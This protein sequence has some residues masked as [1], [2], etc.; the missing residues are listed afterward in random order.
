MAYEFLTFCWTAE[1]THACCVCPNPCIRANTHDVS[2]YTSRCSYTCAIWT[3]RRRRLFCSYPWW[4]LRRLRPRGRQQLWSVHAPIVSI[5]SRYS[6]N[7]LADLPGD[8]LLDEHFGHILTRIRVH[9]RHSTPFQNGEYEDK[10]GAVLSASR[11]RDT[12]EHTALCLFENHGQMNIPIKYLENVQP[13]SMNEEAVILDGKDKGKVVVVR[14]NPD[15]MVTVST[16]SDATSVFEVS[17]DRLATLY[18]DH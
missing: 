10:Y 8:W 18:P 12:F 14:E 17:R 7:T 2:A 6:Y 15:E 4:N 9:V 13:S 3:R 1:C 11:N 16:T 5:R